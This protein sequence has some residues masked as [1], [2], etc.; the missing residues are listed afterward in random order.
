[1]CEYYVR[2]RASCSECLLMTE[3][4]KKLV[5]RKAPRRCPVY[6]KKENLFQGI[7]DARGLTQKM[8]ML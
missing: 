8:Q 1:M 4:Y 7:N 2:E 5:C 3:L 6:V